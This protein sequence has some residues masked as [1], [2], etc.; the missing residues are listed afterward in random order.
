MGVSRRRRPDVTDDEVVRNV[1]IHSRFAAVLIALGVV[2]SAGVM[3]GPATAAPPQVFSGLGSSDGPG[4]GSARVFRHLKWELP[5]TTVPTTWT[6][7]VYPY[8]LQGDFDCVEDRTNRFSFT[9]AVPSHTPVSIRDDELFMIADQSIFNGCA[10]QPSRQRW[11]LIVRADSGDTRY[12]YTK[13]DEIHFRYTNQVLTVTAGF[14]DIP[15]TH[16]GDTLTARPPK[17]LRN[18]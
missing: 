7:T 2:A 8:T 11:Q 12:S 14:E 10:Q 5:E 13:R 17:P 15:I 4:V 3:S 16:T 6:I 18:N 1:S 9:Q